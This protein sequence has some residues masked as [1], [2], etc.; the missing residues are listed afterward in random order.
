MNVLKKFCILSWLVLIIYLALHFVLG[1]HISI[2]ELAH[3]NQHK[4]DEE[5]SKAMYDHNQHVLTKVRNYM[6]P[7]WN[8]N[9]WIY[10][11]LFTIVSLLT[12]IMMVFRSLISRRNTK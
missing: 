2:K 8:H 3:N 11:F 5:Y 12:L 1:S 10:P 9:K 4:S 7:I 6:I